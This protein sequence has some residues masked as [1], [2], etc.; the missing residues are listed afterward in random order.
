MSLIVPSWFKGR[1]GKAEPAGEDLYRL[2]APN[3][4]DCFIGLRRGE[5]G[6]WAAFLRFAQDGPDA[7]ATEPRFDNVFDA[8]EAAFELHRQQVVV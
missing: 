3:L 4:R 2:T 1:Q 6:R 7:A 8:W 5:G